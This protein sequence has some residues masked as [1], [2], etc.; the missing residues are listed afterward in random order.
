MNGHCDGSERMGRLI[1]R[2]VRGGSSEARREGACTPPLDAWLSEAGLLQ[3]IFA[4][5]GSQQLFRGSCTG[6]A[7]RVFPHAFSRVAKSTIG[8]RSA[9]L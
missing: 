1:L 5:A 4:R 6:F 8:S 2:R 3:E 7:Q 9:S